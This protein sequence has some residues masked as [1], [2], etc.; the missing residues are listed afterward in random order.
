MELNQSKNSA[1]VP[2]G[3]FADIQQASER[4]SAEL[5]AT[6]ERVHEARSEREESAEEL[7]RRNADSDRI[8]LSEAARALSQPAA[9]DSSRQSRVDE[10]RAAAEDGSLFDRDRLARAA[11]RLLG[12]E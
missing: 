1:D 5:K 12:A 3:R 7:R 9:E 10:L 8:D 11:E 4:R 6:V 2:A